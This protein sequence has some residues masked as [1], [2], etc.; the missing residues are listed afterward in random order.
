M[1]S[2]R[3][4]GRKL[5]AV[6]NLLRSP[7]AIARLSRKS[8]NLGNDGAFSWSV[9]ASESILFVFQNISGLAFEC[10]TDRFQS[11]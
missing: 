1:L 4:D 2:V 9:A 10:L 8:F 3:C 5:T 7:T 11:G 6:G